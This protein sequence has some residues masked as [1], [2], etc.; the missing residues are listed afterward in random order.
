MLEARSREP[1]RFDWKWS[2]GSRR[3]DG[4]KGRG[5]RSSVKRNCI[6]VQLVFLMVMSINET[7]RGCGRNAWS[8]GI[9]FFG[10]ASISGVIF[11]GRPPVGVLMLHRK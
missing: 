7:V 2:E 8:C 10:Q 3:V 4:C 11:R 5:Y 6:L 1:H 9:I